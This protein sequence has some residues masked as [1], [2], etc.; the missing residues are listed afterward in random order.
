MTKI[1]HSLGALAAAVGALVAVGLVVLTLLAV[2]AQPVGAKTELL[3]DKDPQ[4]NPYVA[5]ELLVAYKKQ[6][7][8][9]TFK[10]AQDVALKVVGGK[11]E[12]DFLNIGVQH[13][14][15]PQVKNEQSREARQAALERIKHVLEQDPDVKS[16]SYN[17]VGGKALGSPTTR[18]TASSGLCRT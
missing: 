17:H 2:E 7:G 10:K 16:V 1:N 18:I 11:V 4:G 3:L 5:G 13:I 15:L 12:K 14:S 8:A 9:F 6:Q